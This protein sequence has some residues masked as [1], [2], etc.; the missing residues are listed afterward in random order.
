MKKL[1]LWAA[2]AAVG[3]SAA[4]P[5]AAA[6]MG[7]IYK[8][9]PVPVFTWSGFFVGGY[10]GKAWGS[11]TWLENESSS[12]TGGIAAPGFTDSSFS[13]ND[14]LG[15]G[16]FGFDYQTGWV[17]WG[18]YVDAGAGNIAGSSGCFSQLAGTSQACSSSINAVGS[19]GARL[20]VAVDRVLLYGVAGWAWANERNT[21]ACYNCGPANLAT[22]AQVMNG[23]TAGA[24]VEYAFAGN[25]SAFAQYNY[26]DFGTWGSNF[27]DGAVSNLPVFTENIRQNLSIFKSGI[28]FRFGQPNVY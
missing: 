15:G 12:A 18:A 4:V 2:A 13:E 22:N 8:A 7:A 28:N 16:Q 9:P 1:A 26:I 27:S 14:W 17:V 23:W 20:G 24:G 10:F 5:A 3:L 11:T 21:N 6:D 25:W 19:A